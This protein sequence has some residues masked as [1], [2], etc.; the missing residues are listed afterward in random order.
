M[1]SVSPRD[2]AVAESFKDQH[3]AGFGLAAD[4]LVEMSASVSDPDSNDSSTS[5]QLNDLEVPFRRERKITIGAS[6]LFERATKSRNQEY[7][8]YPSE[9]LSVSMKHRRLTFL[10]ATFFSKN[11]ICWH[12]FGT[13]LNRDRYTSKQSNVIL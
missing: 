10:L 2:G 11:N 3:V 13:Q 8:Y 6:P 9:S 12:S 4:T 5:C 1:G 7:L